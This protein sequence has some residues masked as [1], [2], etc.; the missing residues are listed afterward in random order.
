MRTRMSRGIL[1]TP[2]GFFF[3]FLFI[4][5][6]FYVFCDKNWIFLVILQHLL[7]SVTDPAT[8]VKP[9]GVSD[10]SVDNETD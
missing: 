1:S 7:L 10:V 9:L 2:L 5:F 6:Q 8:R 3:I 4:Y